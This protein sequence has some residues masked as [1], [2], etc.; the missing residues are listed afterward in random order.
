[1]RAAFSS[2]P[3]D[4]CRPVITATGRTE[5]TPMRVSDR[6]ISYSRKATSA[7]ISLIATTWSEM[8]ANR[9]MWREMPRG[10]A[11]STLSG[12]SS[13]GV[14]HGRSRRAGSRVAE[15]ICRRDGTGPV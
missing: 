11:T 3:S 6:S 8:R 12:H 1:M 10:S 13:R 14:V 5:G 7:E 4:A 9:T 2:S 15:V